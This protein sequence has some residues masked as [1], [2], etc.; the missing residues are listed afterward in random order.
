MSVEHNGS[1]ASALNPIA[2]GTNGSHP[3]G[4][5]S[6]RNDGSE[7]RVS[8]SA[9]NEPRPSADLNK[10]TAVTV[11]SADGDLFCG[12]GVKLN[13]EIETCGVLTIEGAVEATLKARQLIVANSGSFVGKAIV[14]DA[15]ID[16]RFEG[17]LQI[18]GKLLVRR[19][20]R[21]MGQLTY[22][23]IEVERG[24]EVR[25]KLT[26]QFGSQEK[27]VVPMPLRKAWSRKG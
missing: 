15:E 8:Y 14:E 25:G 18:S 3:P 23:Q 22:G 21:V 4:G 12:A 19:T 5:A 9:K 17:T 20:G 1:G 24:G 16:G 2:K 6:L 7:T 11:R 26:V 13:G 10:R 27:N